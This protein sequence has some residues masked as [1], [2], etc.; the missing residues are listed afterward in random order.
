MI[1]VNGVRIEQDAIAR[2]MQHHPAGSREDAEQQAATALVVRELLLQRVSEQEVAGATED[3]RIANLIE[4][5]I[6]VPEPKPEEIA[7]YYR[8]NG[9]QFTSPAIYR[10]A[11]IFFPARASDEQAS[12]D[13][14]A[15]AE[16]ALQ[17][18]KAAEAK[19]SLHQSEIDRAEIKAPYDG[20]VLRGELYDQVGSPVKAGDPIMEVQEAGE[21]M[22][23]ELAVAERR[24][25]DVSRRA[26]LYLERPSGMAALLCQ[27][28]LRKLHLGRQHAAEH[29]V[30]PPKRLA[31]ATPAKR[32]HGDGARDGGRDH[33]VPT[34]VTRRSVRAGSRV[35]ADASAPPMSTDPSRSSHA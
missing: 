16:A 14:R 8:R 18:A 12:A 3:E 6:H 22:E 26:V 13:A 34:R 1:S 17:Q 11:H 9:L 31:V 35:K 30:L 4:Q 32:R 27:S 15:K 24:E 28:E 19:I 33:P 2:E 10:A 29:G 21:Q 5:E 25:L 20:V 23:A 7:R